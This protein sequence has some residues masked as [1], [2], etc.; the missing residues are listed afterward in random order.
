IRRNRLLLEL[1][2]LGIAVNLFMVPI[3]SV[4]VPT[5]GRDVFGGAV[6]F[7]ALLLG[8]RGGMVAGNWVAGWLGWTA[9]RKILAGLLLV[10]VAAVSVVVG[11][12][13]LR[14]LGWLPGLLLASA[15]LFL[16]GVGQPLFN[17][18]TSSL[19]QAAPEESG[20]GRVVTFVNSVLQAS[21][22][23]PLLLAG[24]AVTVVSPVWLFVAGG[25]GLVGVGIAVE[26][27]FELRPA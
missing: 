26:R 6:G 5:L 20:R 15:A 22:P 12:I 14:W 23:V 4:L 19:L 2:A 13:A 27:R 3:P 16:V 17:V 11:V 7:T 21:F 9:R 8:L 24:A 25:V 18:P 10:G 1:L